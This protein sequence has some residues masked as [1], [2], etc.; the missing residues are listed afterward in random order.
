MPSQA[1]TGFWGCVRKAQQ[2]EQRGLEVG[3]EIK[4]SERT[5]KNSDG[6]FNKVQMSSGVPGPNVGTINGKEE[7]EQWNP[8]ERTGE[9]ACSG[10]ERR[11]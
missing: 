7:T 8:R 4:A 9:N 2:R 3:Q 5:L 11:R 6:D 1:K 10:P